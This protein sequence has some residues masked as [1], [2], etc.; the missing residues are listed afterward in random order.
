MG[1]VIQE[2]YN[3][4]CTKHGVPCPELYNS[5]EAYKCKYTN[6]FFKCF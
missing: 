6:G 1:Q 5:A 2:H 4:E 3:A